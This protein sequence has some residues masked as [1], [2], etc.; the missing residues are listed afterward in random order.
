M[1]GQ[2]TLYYDSGDKFTGQFVD[3]DPTHGEFITTYGDRYV[4]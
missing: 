4:G 1:N 3:G 2:G